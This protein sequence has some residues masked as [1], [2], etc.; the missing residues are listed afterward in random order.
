MAADDFATVAAVALVALFNDASPLCAVVRRAA[1]LKFTWLA[2]NTDA[3]HFW[4]V[5]GALQIAPVVYACAIG[6][7]RETECKAGL[8]ECL[9]A[10]V[11]ELLDAYTTLQRPPH[12]LPSLPPLVTFLGDALRASPRAAPSPAAVSPDPKTCP[13]CFRSVGLLPTRC[14]LCDQRVCKA[15]LVAAVRN[16]GPAPA[17]L[18]VCLRCF[19][20][21]AYFFKTLEAQN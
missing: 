7:T 5:R 20:V 17:P 8:A 6:T 15:C 21:W 18:L 12:A 3:V 13:I 14:A 2:H 16:D 11:R 19:R 9:A 10:F 4:A 1:L